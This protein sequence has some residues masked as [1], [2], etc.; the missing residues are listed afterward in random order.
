MH[1][2]GIRVAD[3]ER[4]VRFYTEVFD[5]TPLTL[6]YLR[7]GPEAESAMGGIPGVRYLVCQLQLS[8]GVVEP[9]QFLDPKLPTGPI[10]APRGGVLHFGLQVP[11]VPRALERL[12]AAGGKRAWPEVRTMGTVHVIY[13]TD[14]DGNL[15]EIL[16]ADAATLAEVVIA[17]NPDARYRP[18]A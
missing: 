17:A 5:G 14:P 1:H 12:E 6:P 3:I 7:E 15:I 13:A 16:D 8:N 9:F 10:A 11:D 4:S 2:V 18:P